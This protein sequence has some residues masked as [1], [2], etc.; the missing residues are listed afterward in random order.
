MSD[1]DK[2]DDESLDEGCPRADEEDESEDGFF[3]PDGY[4]SENEVILINMQKLANLML[5]V[6]SPVGKLEQKK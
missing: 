3:V 5:R 6:A 1:C 4:L 2:N